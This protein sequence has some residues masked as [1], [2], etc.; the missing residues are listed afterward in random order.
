MKKREGRERESEGWMDG[1]RSRCPPIHSLLSI[2]LLTIYLRPKISSP[3][4]ST[5]RVQRGWREGQTEWEIKLEVEEF[6][7]RER[8]KHRVKERWGKLRTKS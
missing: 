4:F 8:T 5:H 3:H 7:H 1:S 2:L 6:K